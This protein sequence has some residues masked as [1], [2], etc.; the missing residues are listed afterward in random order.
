[1]KA[2]EEVN[3]SPGLIAYMIPAKGALA[4]ISCQWARMY[5]VFGMSQPSSMNFFVGTSARA[6]RENVRKNKR[7]SVILRMI[8]MGLEGE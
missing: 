1:M 3:L 6:V 8:G 7:A 5:W 2:C 4:S